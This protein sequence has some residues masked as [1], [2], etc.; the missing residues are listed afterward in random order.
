MAFTRGRTKPRLELLV[1]TGI[2]DWLRLNFPRADAVILDFYHAAEHLCDWAKALHSDEAEAKT[3]GS[4]RC[5]CSVSRGMAHR[6]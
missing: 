1:V 2:E 4:S 5:H 3:V 6:A